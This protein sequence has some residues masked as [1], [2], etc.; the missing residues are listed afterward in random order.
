MA[1][2]VAA[3][4]VEPEVIAKCDNLNEVTPNHDEVITSVAQSS[5]ESVSIKSMI[6]LIRGQEMKQFEL[7]LLDSDLAFLYG[8]ETRRLN[9]QVK[10]NIERSLTTSCF[11]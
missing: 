6:R 1:K 2:K 9:E 7:S 11:S 5:P 10:R 4:K 3:E 8:V